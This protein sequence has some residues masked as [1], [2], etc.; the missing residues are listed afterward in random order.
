MGFFGKSSKRK[1]E[2]DKA[3]AATSVM[4]LRQ[5]VEDQDKRLVGVID[6]DNDRTHSMLL[7]HLLYHH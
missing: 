4:K 1:E 2:T 3:D 7:A 5:A 6:G